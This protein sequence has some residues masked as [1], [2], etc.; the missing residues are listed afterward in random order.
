MFII[1]TL[2]H[3][4]LKIQNTFLIETPT[5]FLLFH[6]NWKALPSHDAFSPNKEFQKIHS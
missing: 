2:T 4:E 1:K 5:S 6:G 3:N